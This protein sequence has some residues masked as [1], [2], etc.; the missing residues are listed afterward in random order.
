MDEVKRMP[1]I[2]GQSKKDIMQMFKCYIE[3]FNTAT[4]PHEKYYNIERWEMLE[5][6]RK[7]NSN[8]NGKI[9]DTFDDE[10]ERRIE[11][12]RRKE[13]ET[14]LEFMNLKKQMVNDKDRLEDMRRQNELVKELQLAY[15][16][17][18]KEKVKNI[19]SRLTPDIIFAAK[20]PWA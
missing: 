16:Q 4:L 3:D 18:D 10:E 2:F 6:Q 12:K 19:E 11:L 1:G 17:G 9:K 14:R 13:E 7:Q 8:N 15:K 20:H 5:Y